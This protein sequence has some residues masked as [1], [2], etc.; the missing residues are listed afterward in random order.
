MRPTSSRR[1]IFGGSWIATLVNLMFIHCQRRANVVDAEAGSLCCGRSRDVLMNDQCPHKS[2]STYKSAVF[3][4]NSD[5]SHRP[6]IEGLVVWCVSRFGRQISC[7]PIL[8]ASS[9]G[10]QLICHPLAINQNIS[11]PYNLQDMGGKA[12][13]FGSGFLSW[14]WPIGYVSS[15]FEMT[16]DV[17]TPRLYVVF[18]RLLN[19]AGFPACWRPQMWP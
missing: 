8:V 5:S 13:P 7:Q 1:F 18:Q 9:L 17:L 4:S 11:K 6:L 2:W 3:G 12:A 19:F 16:A 14:H 10:I 15:F